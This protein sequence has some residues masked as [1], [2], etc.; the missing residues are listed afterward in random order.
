[1]KRVI[2]NFTVNLRNLSLDPPPS[3]KNKKNQIWNKYQKRSNKMFWINLIKYLIEA[4]LLSAVIRPLHILRYFSL[5]RLLIND[6][7]DRTLYV[8]DSKFR[9]F[10][11]TITL[12]QRHKGFTRIPH[13]MTRKRESIRVTPLSFCLRVL[14]KKSL[15]L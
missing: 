3:K 15:N 8:V 12:R 1:M 13:W 10:S 2:S 6:N 5:S 7:T 9:G 14:N 11:F 4:I